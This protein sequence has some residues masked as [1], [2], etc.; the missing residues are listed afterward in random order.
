MEIHPLILQSGGS[1]IAILALYGLAR[2]LGLGGSPSLKDADRL[3]AV[4]DEVDTGFIIDRAAVDRDGASALVKDA[5]GRVMAIKRHGNRFAGR[6]LRKGAKVR[7]EVDAIVIDC[8]EAR[9]GTVRLSID[10]PA[11][12]ADTINRL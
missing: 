10:N 9:F 5:S 3:A 6:I 4:A 1:L 12:W 7:E 2:W 11:S 8:G